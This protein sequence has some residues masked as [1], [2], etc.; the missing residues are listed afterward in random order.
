MELK[1]DVSNVWNTIPSPIRGGIYLAGFGIV[2]YFGYKLYKKITTDSPVQGAKTDLETLE[3]QGIKP[4]LTD[5]QIQGMV[6][7]LK[8][9]AAGQRFGGT[10][11]QAY[12]DVF[13]MLKN[14]A[15]FNKLVIGFGEERKSFSL[16][17]ADL[18][19]YVDHELNETELAKV[20]SI[21]KQ[22]NI[23]YRI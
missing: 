2:A 3:I 7:K 4:T 11:E 6:T 1:K 17:S 18:F 14:D 8:T 9:N 19:G 16:A 20:N 23:K 12:Y 5:A 21:L 22:R 13:S 15:D 10:N